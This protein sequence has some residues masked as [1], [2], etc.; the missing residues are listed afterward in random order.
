[1]YLHV[2]LLA[3]VKARTIDLSIIGRISDYLIPCVCMCVCVSVADS[4]I[5]CLL[6]RG[7][8]ARH[9][10][11]KSPYYVFRTM[12]SIPSGGGGMDFKFTK[13]PTIG[14]ADRPTDSETFKL[15]APSLLV[16]VFAFHYML[17]RSFS[18]FLPWVPVSRVEYCTVL[19]RAGPLAP[20]APICCLLS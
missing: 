17:A 14:S 4:K 10:E 3:V 13:G 16:G 15:G 2:A 6:G 18:M 1:M 8:Q 20:N 11:T 7:A 19:Y 5:I 12:Q 9:I